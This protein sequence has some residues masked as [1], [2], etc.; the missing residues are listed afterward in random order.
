MPDPLTLAVAIDPEVA[1]RIVHRSV[2]VE[3]S[4]EHTAGMTVVDHFGVMGLEPN[5]QVVL[6]AD[7]ERFMTNLTRACT[8]GAHR[9]HRKENA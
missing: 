9:P 7:H 8:P 5:V 3:T 2:V 4:G 6:R 1:T